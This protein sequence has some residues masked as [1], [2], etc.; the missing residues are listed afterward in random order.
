MSDYCY[1][2]RLRIRILDPFMQPMA[3]RFCLLQQNL[4]AVLSHAKAWF[5]DEVSFR[6]SCSIPEGRG[7]SF[8]KPGAE[9]LH[10]LKPCDPIS[11]R[12]FPV[13]VDLLNIHDARSSKF[14]LRLSWC[15]DPEVWSKRIWFQLSNFFHLHIFWAVFYRSP[16]KF[17]YILRLFKINKIKDDVLNPIWTGIINIC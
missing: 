4:P 13:F 15:A 17:K 11:E 9:T 5:W 1:F 10:F 7:K 14:R 3:F 6:L 8:K 12:T 2:D 16:D